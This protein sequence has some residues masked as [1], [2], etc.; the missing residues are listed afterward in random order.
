MKDYKKLAQAIMANIGGEAN[1]ESLTHCVTRLRFKLKDTNKVNEAELKKVSGVLKT[2]ISGGQY[3]VVIGQDVADVYDAILADYHVNAEGEVAA[4]PAETEADKKTGKHDIVGIIADLVSAIFMPFMGAFMGAGL[5]K[6]FLVLFTTLGL[7]DKTG[8]TYTILYAA[9][10]GVFFFLPIFLA[11]TAG[12]KFGA[13]P[14]LTMA[15]AAAMLYPN[16]LALKGAEN[17]VTFFGLPVTMISYSST[18]FPIIIAAWVQAK[19]E[20]FFDRVL[21]TV[22]KN[23]FGPVLVMLIC[24]PLIVLV[25]GPVTDV[26]GRWIAAGIAWF[27]NTMPLVGGFLLASLWPVMIIFGLHW[28]LVPI[29]MNNLAVTGVD[30]ILPL[31][32]GTNF[33]I[34]AACL[35]ISMKS[36]NKPFKEL[37][38]AAGVTGLVGG[39]TEPAIYGVLMKCKKIFAAVILINGI[40]GAVAGFFHVTRDTMIS[41]N[42][43]TLPA[44]AAIYGKWGIVAIVISVVGAFAAAYVMYSDKM[45]EENN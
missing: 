30:S 23:V 33:G 10:D 13:K 29:V 35:A 11:Y 44:I 28:G 19:L 8:T 21:P 22:I 14:F 31:T 2:M 18:V 40:G 26:L 15:I 12:K 24:F 1:V 39:V 41:V 4:D 20:K 36:K 37:A 42:A 43:L 9:A 6:G 5:L 7:I 38:A 3:Q 27:L 16:F 32:V 45:I 17:P 34:S 25:V